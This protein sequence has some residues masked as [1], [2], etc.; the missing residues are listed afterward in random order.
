ME[1]FTNAKTSNNNMAQS[2]SNDWKAKLKSFFTTNKDNPLA[3]N[4]I[5]YY[6]QYI[7]SS[8]VERILKKRNR[9]NH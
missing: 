8:K 3:K 9:Y 5:D 7:Y 6:H 1:S 4:E 2:T